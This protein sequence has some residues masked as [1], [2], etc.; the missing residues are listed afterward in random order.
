[1]LLKV[2]AHSDLDRLSHNSLWSLTRGLEDFN[3]IV[4][5][6]SHEPPYEGSDWTQCCDRP[7][8]S[9]ALSEPSTMNSYR[10]L[11]DMLRPI[12]FTRVLN[13]VAGERAKYAAMMTHRFFTA[14]SA[15]IRMAHQQ[16]CRDNDLPWGLMCNTTPGESS[17]TTHTSDY[18]SASAEGS[19]ISL[20]NSLLQLSET[21]TAP[22]LSNLQSPVLDFI[23]R[24]RE[25]ISKF[26]QIVVQSTSLL[27]R[28]VPHTTLRTSSRRRTPRSSKRR[29]HELRYAI[30]IHHSYKSL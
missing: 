23:R 4:H 30:F 6:V 11:S 17:S 7:M 9:Q 21:L 16:V 22:D 10:H 13:M 28:S 14:D 8:T 19:V 15:F 12:A 27:K 29:S 3:H 25:F 1:M 2:L 5:I 18:H 24:E 20:T 26:L